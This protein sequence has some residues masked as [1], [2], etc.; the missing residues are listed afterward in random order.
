MDARR[1][2][3]TIKPSHTPFDKNKNASSKKQAYKYQKGIR[4]KAKKGAR[5]SKRLFTLI[6]REVE[7]L[8]SSANK[9]CI[10]FKVRD[11]THIGAQT[12]HKGRKA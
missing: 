2:F 1:I 12:I 9:I 3:P 8:M 5:E 11:L 10:P 4:K 6:E 7:S